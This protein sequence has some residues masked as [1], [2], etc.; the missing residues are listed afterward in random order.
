M[1][2]YPEAERSLRK[3][4]MGRCGHHPPQ[5]TGKPVLGCMCGSEVVLMDTE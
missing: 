5:R 3:E 4:E 2:W 1:V